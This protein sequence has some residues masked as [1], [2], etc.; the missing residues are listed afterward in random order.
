MEQEQIDNKIPDDE[1]FCDV[2]GMT[3][4]EFLETG[5]FR[6]E[7]CYRVFKNRTIQLIKESMKDR[8]KTLKPQIITTVNNSRV[9]NSLSS[10]EIKEKVENLEKLLEL[11][12]Q[13]DDKEKIK[14]I[15]EEINRLKQKEM[16]H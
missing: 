4:K 3:Y 9:N 11:A 6:C 12:K 7:N 2:C 1:I 5:V 14:Q 13:L 8:R 15:V 10:K 16:E